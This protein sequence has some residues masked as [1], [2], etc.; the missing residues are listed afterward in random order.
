MTPCTCTTATFL[1]EAIVDRDTP[2]PAPLQ[3]EEEVEQ[4]LAAL[5]Q[6][7]DGDRAAPQLRRQREQEN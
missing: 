5:R 1:V 3:P 6:E 4:M 2:L 7:T